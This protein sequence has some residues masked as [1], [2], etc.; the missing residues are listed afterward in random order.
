LCL[1]D[2]VSNKDGHGPAV[3]FRAADRV[4]LPRPRRDYRECGVRARLACAD[5]GRVARGHAAETQVCQADE[6]R[7]SH[8][9]Y[10]LTF[11]HHFSIASRDHYV[12]DCCFGGDL[13]VQQLLPVVS[14]AEHDDIQTNQE[15]WGWFIWFRRGSLRMSIDVNC[16]DIECGSFAI[17][18]G[19]RRPRLL[20]GAT[21]VDAPELDS[22]RDQVV[23]ALRR[24][25]N[26]D[27]EV[28]K[29][30]PGEIP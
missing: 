9:T 18:L 20:F 17:H 4:A 22:L 3:R 19:A 10:E 28:R 8:L 15:D 25:L 12:N 21:P 23:A 11:T 24:W 1:C 7:C 27:P 30:E 16:Q 13:I 2:V 14:I 6:K 5:Y 29:L 26:V